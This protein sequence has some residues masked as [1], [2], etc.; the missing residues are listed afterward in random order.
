MDFDYD[1]IPLPR[2]PTLTD[3]VAAKQAQD[4]YESIS[5][6]H[7]VRHFTNQPVPRA[8]IETCLRAAGTAPSGAN[9]QPWHF[10]CVSNPEVKRQIR[11]AAEAEE[12]AFYGGK[13]GDEWLNDLK[14][15]GTDAHKPFLEEAPWLIAIFLERFGTDDEGN[16][17]KNY[18]TAN[19]LASQPA[20]F[21]TPCI[22]PGLRPL[23]T[24]PTR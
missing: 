7:T 22:K 12:R 23:H 17:R 1:P 4:Y 24:H 14:K 11:E 8:T 16:K 6:R 13:A 3:E 19:L 5:S 10:V 9:H 2:Q 18:Y 15:I 21:S 20:F